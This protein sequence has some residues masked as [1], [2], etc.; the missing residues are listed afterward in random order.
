M[1]LTHSIMIGKPN[2]TYWSLMS[3]MRELF[4]FIE[5]QEKSILLII[6]QLWQYWTNKTRVLKIRSI[7]DFFD[8][9]T[10]SNFIRGRGAVNRF[11]A[12]KKISIVFAF[13]SISIYNSIL[14]KERLIMLFLRY[15]NSLPLYW[16][17]FF[18]DAVVI[19]VLITL[20]CE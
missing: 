14:V 17:S 2:A 4:V 6:D 19:S 12:L 7:S 1:F 18:P 20:F 11:R 3:L 15:D 16:Y 9:I 10:R 13:D 5:K 8:Q